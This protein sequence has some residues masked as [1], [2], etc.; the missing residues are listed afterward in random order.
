MAAPAGAATYPAGFEE[1]VVASGMTQPVAVDWAPDG[2]AFLA[3]KEGRVKVVPPGGGAATLLLD[4]SAHVNSYSD[5]GLNGIAVD[6]DFATNGFVYLT[7][8][9]D[10][11]PMNRDSMEPMASRV[12]RIRILPSGALANPSSPETVILGTSAGAACPAPPSNAVDCIP[13]DEDSHTMGTI[14]SA[15]DGTLW[16]GT[17]DGASYGFADSRALRS[18]DET[19]LAGK[20]LH[21]DRNGQGLASHAFCPAN[22]NLSHNCTKVYAKGFRNPFRFHERPGGGLTVA[23]VGWNT[24]EEF[25]VVAQAGGSYGWPCY[26]GKVKTPEYKDFPDCAPY[27][28]AAAEKA[29]DHD[30]VH[31]PGQG[32]AIIGGPTFGSGAYPAGYAGTTFFGDFV[33]Q[34]LQRISFAGGGP[35]VVTD[36][37]EGWFATDMELGPGG[38]LYLVSPGNFLPGDG[39]LSRVVYTPENA[40]PTAE[41][42]A[43]VT[44]GEAP[45]AVD[46]TGSASTDP[47][48]DDL[49]YSWDFG[50]G[51][52]STSAD[53]SHTYTS[54]GSYAAT[55]TVTDPGG[56]SDSETVTI[57]PGNAAPTATIY[58]PLDGAV[59]RNG[60]QVQLRGY[61][62]DP[63]DTLPPAALRWDVKL[64]HGTHVHPITTLYGPEPQFTPLTDHDADSS[65][66]V[67]LTA[68]DPQS[69][70]SVATIDLHPQTVTVT[71]ASSPPGAEMS[72][73]GRAALAP[74]SQATAVGY[75]P[76][77]AAPEEFL[78]EGRSYRFVAWEND[79]TERLRS[80]VVPD[81]DFALI[82]RYEAVAV[83]PGPSAPGAPPVKPPV[84]KPPGVPGYSK[85]VRAAR[86]LAAFYGLGDR[87]LRARDA[88]G[89]RPGRYLGGPPRAQSLI[90]GATDAAHA[91]DGFNDAA[92]LPAAPLRRADRF[93]AEAWIHPEP[94]HTAGA[95]R[96]I[97]S[98]ARTG[99]WDGFDLYLDSRSR[100]RLSV[101]GKSGKAG[102]VGPPLAS[103][104]TYH[105]VGAYNAKHL[106]VYVNGNRRASFRH[107]AT[108]TLGGKVRLGHPAASRIGF[109][110]AFRGRMDDLALYRR[111]LTAAEVR[112]HWAARLP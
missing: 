109:G 70:T 104:V 37:A 45:L 77:V 95:K 51:A 4:I 53:P 12:T 48:G 28:A 61:A 50:D 5:R 92:D 49:D 24:R 78:S 89:G 65:Y 10:R 30:Y 46:F 86:G 6:R 71:V 8:V 79:S 66:E 97:V 29:P 75:E 88:K 90:A 107:K 14:R 74:Y 72:Y 91:F 36:F 101:S 68:T 64:H 80:L 11:L 56:L 84:A 106:T 57:T 110:G 112:R 58:E 63:D 85:V 55:L 59:Y 42:T 83:D 105:V 94:P 19:S 7:Y 98:S 47:D 62:T 44:G 21:V 40:S 76:T 43:S 96:F 13:A 108:F 41:V 9:Y 111:A 1:R 35:P 33:S 34:K 73:A 102:V 52:S 18:L 26:E 38:D 16:I 3:E 15:Q 81:S 27:Y 67:T 99:A 32:G 100:L 31:P 54:E 69:A 39:S 23:D 60:Q 2:Q 22:A 17:G 93:T 20:V 87:D 25:N 103:N 82:A